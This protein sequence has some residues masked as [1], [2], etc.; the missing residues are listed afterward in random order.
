[1]AVV[2]EAGAIVVGVQDGQ[3][4]I[5]LVTAKR[6]PRA[7][8]FPK[9]HLEA[10]ETPETAA[11][12]EA[13]EEAGVRGRVIGAAGVLSFDL[14]LDTYRV[15]YF[16]LAT[17]DAGVA[18]AGRS[19]RWYRYEDALDRVAFTDAR[20]LLRDAQPLVEAA[21]RCLSPPPE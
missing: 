13:R 7:W 10:G 2:D 1:M 3:P 14:G 5:L 4:R 12:R 9:G 6:D 20:A 11:V 18:E 15:R 19:L 8:I 21:R 17:S 16:V